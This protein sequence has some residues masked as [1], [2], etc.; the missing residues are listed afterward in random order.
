MRM[1]EY[2]G[3]GRQHVPSARRVPKRNVNRLRLRMPVYVT[4]VAMLPKL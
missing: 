1:F 3:T 2:P 4:D